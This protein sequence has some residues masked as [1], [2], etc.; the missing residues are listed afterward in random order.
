[1]QKFILLIRRHIIASLLINFLFYSTAFA[2]LN[3]IDDVGRL[4]SLP[5]LAKRIITLGPEETE[6]LFAIGAEKSIIGTISQSNYPKEALK[7]ERVGNYPNPDFEKILSLAPDLVILPKQGISPNLIQQL[8][9]FK[10]F[11]CRF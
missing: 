3:V 9:K 6:I 1:M 7:I 10:S 11:F 5:Q 4:V 8:N 2:S